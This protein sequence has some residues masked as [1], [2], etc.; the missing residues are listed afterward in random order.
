M[1]EKEV[2]LEWKELTTPGRFPEL[3]LTKINLQ[4]RRGDR[5]ALVGPQF[6]GRSQMIRI[7]GGTRPFFEGEFTF[8][9]ES[10]PNF[11]HAPKWEDP[12]SRKL[13]RKVGACYEKDGLLSNVSVREGLETLFRFKYGDHNKGLIE[14]AHRVVREIS[15]QLGL[16]DEVLESRP[17][18]LN[19][20]QARLAALARVFLSR[21]GIVVLEN[22]TDSLGPIEWERV[23]SALEAMMSDPQRILLISTGDW[24]LASHFCPRWIYVD[25][26]RALFDG[27]AQDFL[28]SDFPLVQQM[29]LAQQRRIDQQ[30]RIWRSVV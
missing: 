1:S 6:A 2:I 9:G 22:P 12:F 25:E 8:F 28:R 7:L 29:K 19:S 23:F 15:E 13:R 10:I 20:A 3:G 21:P 26:G 17:A 18:K 5:I 27:S 4:V 30:S 16:D 24:A 14:G 11:S